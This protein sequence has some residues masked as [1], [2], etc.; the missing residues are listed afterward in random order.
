ME[1]ISVEKRFPTQKEQTP[2]N[3][4]LVYFDEA[5]LMGIQPYPALI[6]RC[7]PYYGPSHWMIAPSAP[8]P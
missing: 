4:I 1:W 6:K 3:R 5:D 2:P 7:I 8:K